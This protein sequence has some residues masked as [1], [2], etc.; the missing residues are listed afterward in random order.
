MATVSE[1]Q[2]LEEISYKSRI[3]FFFYPLILGVIFI[4]AFLNF[5]PVSSQ[6]KMLMKKTLQGTGCNPD[7]DH[8]RLEWFLPKIVISDVTLPAACLGRVGEPLKLN[9]LNLH[10]HFINFAPFGIP[11]KLETEV[12]SQPL[13]LYFVQGFG[14]RLVRIKDQSISL[15]RIQPLLG[16]KFK[17]SGTVLLDFS[18]LMDNNNSLQDLSIK[19]RST[20]FQLPSQNI[21]GFTTPA[22]KVNDFYLEAVSESPSRIILEKFIMGDPNSPL[23]ANFKGKIQLQQ[24]NLGFSPLDLRGE[25]AFTE[26]FKQTVPLVEL[27]FQSYEQKDGF[28]QIRLG[29]TLGQPKLMTP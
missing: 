27:F 5:Y 8:I 4:F 22:V 18:A 21:E 12:N 16:G 23:R 6:L 15:S 9:Y 7:F 20:D 13:A 25:I 1:I 26:N 28:Y 19:G 17:M 14:K 29:G 10:F 11:F 3:K 24:G 2:S